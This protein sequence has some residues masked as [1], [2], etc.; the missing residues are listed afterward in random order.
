MSETLKLT[1]LV[2][3][4]A[5]GKA[6]KPVTVK[7]NFFE[8]QKLPDVTVYHYDVTIS[9]EDLPPAVNRKI[10]EELIASYGK[11]ELGGTRP[12]YDGRKNM[13]S[14]KELKF[15]SKTFDITLDKNVPPN[16]KRPAEVFKVKIRKV[17]TINLEELHRFL[18]KK[19]ALTNNVLT[20]I[21]AL[22]VLIRHKPALLHVTVGSSFFTPEGKQP[23]NGPLE[24]WRGFYQS[25]RPAV[26]KMMINLDISATAFYQ[27]GPLIEIII[28]I[29]GFR[30]PNDLGRTSPPINWEK[31]EKAIKGL[32]VLLT[33][34]EKS[35]KSFKVLKLIQKSARQYKFK[36]D[37]NKNDPQGNPIQV[38][39]SIEAYF[40]KTYG[41][42]LQFPNL[43]C[44][45]IG[46]T[47]I[48]PLELC[49]VTEGQRYPKKLDERQTAD[50]IKFTCQ[51]PHIRA[52]TIKDGLRILNYDNNE[53]IK[54]FGLKISTEMATIKARTL[55]APVI[56][57]HPSSKDANFTPNDG[58]WNLIGKKVAQGT[59]L[60]SWGAVVFGNERDV[61]K[62][63]FDNFIRQLVVTCTAT[64]MN[65]PNKSPPCV[66]ANPH[67]DVEGALRQAW[68]RAGSAVK[69][70]PQLIL[71][72]LPNTGV[73]LYA[74]IK[75][76]TD[77]VLG[78]SSQ[79]I[80]VKHTRDPKPQYCAN[81]CLKINVK[82]GGMNSHLAGNMLPFLTS[83]PTILMGADVSHPPPGDTVR[84]SIAT[85]VGSMDAK[86]SRYSA[87]IRIQAARTETI[88]DLS[89]MGVELL[90]TFY[91]TCGRKPE[92][93]MMYRDGVSEGQFKE[94]LETELAA[95]K[96][97]CHR[98]EPNYNPKIT[99]VVV[100]KRHHAR[101]FPTRREDGDRSGN[102]KSGL[103][104]DTDIVHPCE[105]DF[106]LQ[107]HA[108][109]LGTSRPAHYYV[110][111]DDNKFAADEMQEFTFRLCHLYARCTRTVSMVPPAYYAH[112]VAARARFHSKNEQWSDTAST[113]SGAGDASSFGKLKPELAK[114]MWFISDHSKG[115][116]KTHE[117]RTAA[118]SAAYL[119]PHLQPTMKILDVGCG[120]G[121]ITID[122]AEL[123]PDGSVIGIEYT[124]DP[125][126]KALALAIE[127]GIMNVEFRVGDIHKLDFPD[128]TFDVVHVH[129]VLQHIADPVQAMREMRRV[130][131][132][133]GIVAVR[134]SIVPTWYPESAGLA[135]FWEL[136]A[137][138][139]KAK[140]GNPHPGKY[141]HT[142][143]V[144]AGFD[145]PQ[146]IS[147]AGTWCFS[148]PEEREYWG[149]SMAERTL[150]SAFADT[151]VSGGYATME[152]LKQLEKA[153][154]D[155]VQD[156][157]GWFA[158]LHGEMICRV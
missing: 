141:I 73:S 151:A 121:S 75:R 155:W 117:W 11:S 156:D 96:T 82:L 106:Y 100:Q 98:L 14:A 114:V 34:R 78:V 25:A 142:W 147:S 137:R 129:Q 112:L 111:Y 103:V 66:Y 119:I 92:R 135:A 10:Y 154:R 91:Q 18:N 71:C 62:T 23:L 63:Q 125:L 133:G 113:E 134:E 35:K 132:P 157:S 6:G 105:F 89:D 120:P 136:Q 79:C 143:A 101:F 77:T 36:V 54:D 60:G 39:T 41:R 58:A 83:K 47:A 109:L 53:Y 27:S 61:P 30:N 70:Q 42:K 67:G 21:M 26:G 22:D 2:R 51:P 46:K 32:R 81:V 48:V 131:K 148:T 7:A 130:T 9:S 56:S 149:G 108:G 122:L 93:I 76:V 55:P 85:L 44:I 57:Y 5:V 150:S 20:G 97:A 3:R 128:N 68:Q 158:F 145:R 38:E 84:P 72:I 104:V 52:N 64:G 99:F 45:A 110:L 87:S 95:L 29:L 16:S 146:I 94:T 69:S 153:W 28:K 13:F 126:S 15:D 123:V 124:S 31:V 102:C 144:Q 88:A 33:H 49:S 74:E 152:E 65:I 50:M 118:N 12:V 24:V 115:V 140:G 90:K 59:T 138:M 80:Q 17:A 107:S 116:L 8:V 19:S 127:R 40:Q 37:S 86:A 4:P 43:P 1:E 139:A